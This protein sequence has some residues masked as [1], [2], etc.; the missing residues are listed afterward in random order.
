[1]YFLADQTNQLRGEKSA[2]NFGAGCRCSE[3]VSMEDM[4]EISIFMEPI[5]RAVPV[6]SGA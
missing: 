4:A 6:L 2:D 1:M 3:Y 5:G